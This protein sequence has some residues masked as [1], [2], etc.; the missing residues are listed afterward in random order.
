MQS[1]PLPPTPSSQ[2]GAR[3]LPA[4]FQGGLLKAL[5]VFH[6]EMGDI[7]RMKLAGFDPVVMVGPEAN[8]FVLVSERQSL[9]WRPE[10]DPVEKLLN[11]GVLVMDGQF[12]DDLRRRLN[13]ALHKRLLSGYIA[14]MVRNTDRVTAGWT[15]ST[16]LDMLAEMRRVAL[17]ILMDTLFKTDIAPDLNRLWPSILSALAYISPGPWIFWPGVPRP[18]YRKALRQLDQYLYQVIRARRLA[19]Q[20][21]DPGPDDLL[22]MLL[23]GPQVISD[24]LARD[25]F[26]TLLIAGHDTSTA[27]LSWSLYLLGS[28]PTVLKQAQAEVRHVL[29]NDEPAGSHLHDLVYLDQVIKETQRLYP[30][31]HLGMRRAAKDLEFQGYRIPAGQRVMYSIYLTH[32]DPKVWPDPQ[33]FIPERFAPGQGPD[34]PPYAYLPFGGG[35]RNCLGAAFAQVEVKIVLA[36][37]LQQFN[38]ELTRRSGPGETRVHAHMGATLEPRPGVWMTARRID[39]PGTDSQP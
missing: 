29:S 16:P 19:C 38:L 4:L 26:L 20:S 3:A 33:C 14:A 18:G 37:I 21:T 31:I 9:L 6:A 22:G 5:E 2:A 28:H 12:H 24:E 1:L 8:H 30:P 36:R 15:G 25:Q 7:F 27:L 34:R 13:P 32:R 17:L 10:G 39:S 35:P 11:H 23:S